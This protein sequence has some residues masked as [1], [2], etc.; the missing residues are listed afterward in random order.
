MS[1]S[2]APPPDRAERSQEPSRREVIKLGA[3]AGSAAAALG[4]AGELQSAPA[5]I[6]AYAAG[7][8]IKY[9]MIGTGSRG[10]YLLGHLANIDNGRCV[11]LCDINEEALD[12]AAEVIKTNP[13]KYKDYRELLADKDIEAILIAV[14]LYVHFPITRDALLAGKQTFCEKSLVFKPEEVHALRALATQHSKQ[15]LQVG[16]QRRYSL[17]FQSVKRMIDDGTLGNVTHIQAQW[18]RNPGWTMKPGGKSNPK[19]WRLFREYSGG[20]TA[21][22]ASHH[23]DVADWFF[24]AH[25]DFVIGLGGL[26][27]WHDGREV[28]DNIQ[29][30]FSYPGG[31]KLLYSAITTNQHLPI[32]DS[33]RPEFGMIVMGTAGAVEITLGS[34]NA[35]PTALWYREPAPTTVSPGT[36]KTET[37]AGATFELAGPQKGIPILTPQNDVDWKNDPF[38]TRES[39]LARRW[40][41]S[42]GI[43]TPEEDRNPVDTELISF[44][45]DAKR[46]ARPK[47]DVEVGLADSTAVMLSNLAMDENRRVYFSEIDKMGLDTSAV[48]NYRIPA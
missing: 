45:E 46:G 37:K 28:W 3:V 19:N 16:L 6:K 30:I 17:Y 27:T 29:L 5:F 39:K 48:M 7:E 26:D 13:K 32:L 35:L 40:L 43:I 23:I 44:L 12:H 14:P 18:H 1:E 25:P 22:L 11:A 31:R 41:Y 36:E 34:D 20:L 21:E 8:Q 15:T 33:T 42:K 24:G 10:T 38:L 2:A 9:G 4:N 47:A